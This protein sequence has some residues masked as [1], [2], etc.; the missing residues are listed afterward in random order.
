MHSIVGKTSVAAMTV[1][2][3]SGCASTDNQDVMDI[4]RRLSAAGFQMKLADTPEKMAHLK[5][6]AERRLVPT[7]RDGNTVFVYADA[8]SCKCIYVGSQKDYQEYERLSIKQNVADEQRATAT[9]ANMA[10]QT[11]AEMNWD[12]WGPWRRPILY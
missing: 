8:Q 9:E 12:M 5:R 2:I 4:E 10:A 7:S 3:I 1:L 11:N 6:L